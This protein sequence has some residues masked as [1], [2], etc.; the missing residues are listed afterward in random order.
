MTALIIV[1]VQNDF[2]TGGSLEV[3]SASEIIPKIN[4]LKSH[5][6]RVILTGDWHPKDHWSFAC[7]NHAKTFTTKKL[8]TGVEQM[9]RPA[10]CVQSTEGAKFHKDLNVGAKDIIIHK[11]TNREWDCYSGFGH[12]HENT[13]IMDHLKAIEKIFIV[14]LAL[15]FCVRSTAEDAIKSKKFRKVVIIE[16]CV[17]AISDEGYKRAKRDLEQMGVFFEKSQ[18]IIHIL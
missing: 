4:E 6:S 18:H 5:F 13:H 9:M 8:P 10:H 17:K 7:N 1:D 14:G 16:D 11:G 2:C 15:D 12:T 3:P